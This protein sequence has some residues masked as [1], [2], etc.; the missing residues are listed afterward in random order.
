MNWRKLFQSMTLAFFSV[1]FLV[2]AASAAETVDGLRF[3]VQDADGDTIEGLAAYVEDQDGNQLEYSTSNSTG[4]LNF[5]LG[6]QDGNSYVLHIDPTMSIDCSSCA[7]FEEQEISFTVDYDEANEEWGLV[8]QEF[9]T[10]T[11]ENASRYVTVT[12]TGS[13]G[14]A[15][16]GVYVNA[17]SYENYAYGLT[18]E[19]G[20]FSFAVPEEDE[21]AWSFSTYDDSGVYAEGWEYDVAVEEDGE[22]SVAIEVLATNATITAS[23]LLNGEAYELGDGEYGSVYCYDPVTYS[24]YFWG[25]IDMGSSE[26]TVRV[27]A[28]TYTCEAWIDGYGAIIDSDVTV[29]EN[30]TAEIDVTLISYTAPVNVSLVNADGDTLSDISYFSVF[31]SSR[32]DNE[33]N[34]YYGDYVY[35]DGSNGAAS[36]NLLDGYTYDIGIWIPEETS[37]DVAT[38]KRT[39][40]GIRTVAGGTHYIQN[41]SME[42]VVGNEDTT[43]AVAFLLQEA[44][45]TATVTVLDADGNPD[46]YAWVSAEEFTSYDEFTGDDGWGNYVGTSANGDG[47]ATLYLTSEVDTYTVSAWPTSA[48]DGSTLPPEE[49]QVQPK[50][51]ENIELSMQARAT[52][53]TL[54]MSVT[55]S[56]ATLDYSYCYA[57]A[58][59]VGIDTFVD[60]FDGSGTLGLV[61][62]GVQWYIGCM[63]Y[64]GDT[65]Y[66]SD[67]QLYTTGSKKNG[68]DT[69]SI[70]L[71]DDGSYYPETVYIVP[72]DSTT[73][74][75]LP[76]GE[77]ELTIPSGA[78]ADEGN[79]TLY[80]ET[81]TG[82]TVEDDE[83]PV[84][85]FEFAIYDESGEKQ[86]EDF[87]SNLTLTLKY[88][89]DELAE[90]G[91]SEDSL[92]G[93]SYDDSNNAWGSPVSETVDTE[94]DE[95]SIVLNHFSSYGILGD[96]KLRSVK[97]VTPL[98]PRALKAK[99]IKKKKAR[100]TWKKPKN[101]KHSDIARYR[102]QV[103][104]C[105]FD[106]K[107]KCTKKKH[108]KK[109]RK[110]KKYKKVKTQPKRKIKRKQLKKLQP[111]TFYQFRVRACTD[112]SL[113]SCGEYS[114]WKRFRTKPLEQE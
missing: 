111:D 107:K 103:R 3:A 104:E 60:I 87:N 85:A 37:S 57:Y 71:Q 50:S 29:A 114:K 51:G 75:T 89:E 66:R 20:E 83:Y 34:E 21:S 97:T 86:E 108:Y 39:L 74:V 54:N 31:A 58:P 105:K 109:K 11:M 64:A 92:V 8:L 68:S 84:D 5:Y 44:D 106:T 45:V 59:E 94:K 25:S 13:D 110:W 80:V 14:S 24:N 53:W 65:F 41:Y 28:G 38:A 90:Y 91:I 4:Y 42:T 55:A 112:T 40:T 23:L 36:M 62:G 30:G 12:V 81:A 69:L 72:A 98:R 101:V 63:G 43:Q 82:Y 93:G 32:E 56:D 70:T 10:V 9:D 67:D 2:S 7:L 52:D 48:Y 100:L 88:D 61:S 76:D 19:N 6:Y 46:P 22:T 16:E 35:A 47:V 73:T 95:M 77:S 99:K 102:V 78:V 96:K 1:F 26:G 113:D 27:V 79:L 49:E 15:A 18:D 33:G 17:W